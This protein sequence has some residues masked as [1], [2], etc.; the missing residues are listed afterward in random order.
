MSK[1]CTVALKCH[2]AKASQQSIESQHT[3]YVWH[4]AKTKFVKI[5]SILMLAEKS[6]SWS[7]TTQWSH[8]STTTQLLWLLDTHTMLK[9]PSPNVAAETHTVYL[10]YKGAY[11]PAVLPG[12]SEFKLMLAACQRNQ[13]VQKSYLWSTCGLRLSH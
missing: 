6:L 5:N 1:Q 4:I 12:N 3:G 13:A 7:S 11:G 10:S 2:V 8:F 9:L